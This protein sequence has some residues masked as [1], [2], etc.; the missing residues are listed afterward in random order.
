MMN[1]NEKFSENECVE[2]MRREII[3]QTLKKIGF[4]PDQYFVDEILDIVVSNGIL[5]RFDNK[6]SSF[7]TYASKA[8]KRALE[9]QISE[10]VKQSS[11]EV[12]FE[13]R[14]LNTYDY[15]S[16]LDIDYIIDK[17]N[18]KNKKVYRGL[19]FK[20]LLFIIRKGNIKDYSFNWC[21]VKRKLRRIIEQS[22]YY[23][24]IRYFCL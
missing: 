22:V 3:F 9:R 7:K 12:S 24:D 15:I 20:D 5:V 14:N 21:Y 19:S 8:I 4:I 18:E 2:Y 13:C 6:I 1:S 16:D 11:L 10:W 23:E 17:I